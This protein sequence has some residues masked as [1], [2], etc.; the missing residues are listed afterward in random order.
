MNSGARTP[1]LNS[2]SFLDN[3]AAARHTVSDFG[4][5]AHRGPGPVAL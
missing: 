5:A 1:S 3:M 4:P 2:N